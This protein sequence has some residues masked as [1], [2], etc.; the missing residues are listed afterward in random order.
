MSTDIISCH[1]AKWI[2]NNT[3]KNKCLRNAETG[4]T[5]EI[6]KKDIQNA[7]NYKPVILLHI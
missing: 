1:L 4:T 7:W 2:D 3:C 5:S 6:F